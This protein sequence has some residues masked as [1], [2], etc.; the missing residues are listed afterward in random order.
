MGRTASGPARRPGA[1]RNP[2]PC[3]LLAAPGG[4]FGIRR[5]A[6]AD[7]QP[8][9]DV[10]LP[11]PDRRPARLVPDLL[12]SAAASAPRR[13]AVVAG[14]EVVTYAELADRVDRLAAWLAAA[15]VV[16][17]D[18]IAV[19]AANGTLHCDAYL[20]A[21]RI[22]A[23]C[24]PLAPELAGPEV[25]RLV[26]ETRPALAFADA[27]G[28]GALRAAGLDVV[29]GGDRRYAAAPAM[30]VG[31]PP[32]LPEPSDTVLI[33][34]TSG[35]TGQSKGVCLS[36]AAVTANAAMNAASQGFGDHEV[37]LTSTPLFHA[38]AAARV[39]TMLD[40]A[41]THV[42]MRRF[43]P[44]A[45]IDA[46]ETHRVTSALVV[47]TQV[48]RILDH[49]AYAPE[50]LAS[51]R[52]LVYGAAPSSR[53]QVWRMRRELACG[54]YHGYGLSETTGVVTALTAA[55]HAA[56]TGPNDPR[57]GSIG[58]AIG[59]AEVVVRRPD[60]SEVVP[61]EVG[62]ITVRTAKVMSGYWDDPAATA[63]AFTDGW[64]RTGDLATA[65]GDGCLT[66]VGR[67]KDV[68]ISGGVNIHPAQIERVIAAHPDVEEVAV[69]GIPDPE[70]GEVPVAAVRT[71]PG[72]ELRPEEVTDLVAARLDRRSRP[73]R[74]LFVENFP[75]TATG[76]I[77][78]HGLPSLLE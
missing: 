30:A 66:V 41:H 35:T 49:A 36:H 57:L 48:R 17:G 37:H 72:S 67:S 60:G 24:V 68:I 53:P 58:R 76:K 10:I 39:F 26:A 8:A 52:L 64:L 77:R 27:P 3:R 63:A 5:S 28:A 70:W 1:G 43:D 15:G 6:G 54:L 65:D 19:R 61:G 45:W 46:V 12:A 16:R 34:Y 73:R 51:L 4:S 40:G 33:V 47:P 23:A 44:A 14:S 13:N 31:G 18:R 32:P 56:L 38:S 78:R 20:A 59:G 22:G 55:D 62:E 21:A 69:F 42:L 7:P 71:S 74:V 50:R 9:A 29:V 25:A 75:R 11:A 2:A